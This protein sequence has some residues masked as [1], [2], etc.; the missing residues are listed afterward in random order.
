MSWIGCSSCFT[1][2]TVLKGWSTSWDVN[3]AELR[4]DICNEVFC[5]ALH[6]TCKSAPPPGEQC[7]TDR[8]ASQPPRQC[9]PH[10]KCHRLALL[11][12]VHNLDRNRHCFVPRLEQELH[13]PHRRLHPL[14]CRSWSLPEKELLV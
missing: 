3:C 10:T 4:E 7:V 14:P 8:V 1:D 12:H 5:G 6:A 9:M 13:P 11:S 2:S